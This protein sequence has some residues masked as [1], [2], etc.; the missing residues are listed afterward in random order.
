MSVAFSPMSWRADMTVAIQLNRTSRHFHD[1][2]ITG[3]EDRMRASY[4]EY[5]RRARQMIGDIQRQLAE[6]P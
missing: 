6:K 2:A 5:G 1:P 3:T 4:L